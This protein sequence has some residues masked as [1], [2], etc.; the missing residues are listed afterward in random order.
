MTKKWTRRPP[1][2]LALAVLAAGALPAGT[3][4]AGDGDNPN[5]SDPGGS[6]NLKSGD[7]VVSDVAAFGGG[8]GLIRVIPSNG[9]RNTISEN[10]NPPGFPEFVDPRYVAVE[11]S[12]DLVVAGSFTLNGGT[13]SVGVIRV[14]PDTGARSTVSLTS[15]AGNFPAA[16]PS[17]F[18]PH[19]IAVESNGQIL[20]TDRG[21]HA[22]VRV[23]PVSG[24]RT[25]LSS[26]AVPPAG[27]LGFVGV[28]DLALDATGQILVSDEQG[29]AG[30]NGRGVIFRVDPTTGRRFVV[31][32][33][34]YNPPGNWL[35]IPQGIDVDSRGRVL[36]ANPDLLTPAGPGVLA[37]DPVSGQRSTITNL[38]TQPG[39]PAF[40][41]PEDVAHDPAGGSIYAID[42]RGA[43]NNVTGVLRVRRR[44]GTRTIV[45]TNSSPV[46]TPNFDFPWGVAVYPVRLIGRL[47]LSSSVL[48][49]P[50]GDRTGAAAAG[51]PTFSFGVPERVRAVI[52][53]VRRTTGRVV[54]ARDCRPQTTANRTGKPCLIST[55]VGALT[56]TVA[57]GTARIPFT[58]SFK[59]KP[60]TP[61]TY[62]ATL[63]ASNASGDSTIPS[64][65]DLTVRSR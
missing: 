59:G 29:Q 41:V 43:T 49:I 51:A 31:T 2:V 18:S 35:T 28:N 22:V 64:S 12:G 61:G 24:A 54:K 40:T 37:V 15:A 21:L 4:V 45:S 47:K 46:D 42:N 20:V 33:N 23:D 8:G 27:G 13:T 50:P 1:L 44:G 32:A 39:P 14:D 26:L 55:P 16:G 58:G 30:P 38:F 63:V 10:A 5:G 56:A 36:V 9:R 57:K 53:V 3:A 52:S 60:L 62:R 19:G 48:V 17:F 65:V 25:V 34:G 7:L 6:P 11:R